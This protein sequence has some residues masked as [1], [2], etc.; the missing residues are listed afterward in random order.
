MKEVGDVLLCVARSP[1]VVY[2]SRDRIQDQE[3]VRLNP[4]WLTDATYYFGKAFATLFLIPSKVHLSRP[5]RL[6]T[7]EMLCV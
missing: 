4:L 2:W 6:E 3:L 1:L 5:L 7:I